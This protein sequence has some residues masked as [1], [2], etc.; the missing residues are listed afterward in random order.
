MKRLL[1]PILLEFCRS[2]LILTATVSLLTDLALTLSGL[3]GL[4]TA[5][6]GVLPLP[7]RGGGLELSA[8]FP[9]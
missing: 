8:T 4:G 3:L 6:A 9:P 5:M 2:H 1:R 7:A